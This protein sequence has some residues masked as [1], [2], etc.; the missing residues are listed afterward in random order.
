MPWV[1]GQSGN[2]GGRPPK[3]REQKEFERKMLELS[4]KAA[5]ILARKLDS[6]KFEEVRW[7]VETLLDRGFGKP[8]VSQDLDV[9]TNEQS[10]PTLADI[11]AQ[12]E[13]IKVLIPG[14]IA[15]VPND[16]AQAPGVDTGK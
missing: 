15:G 2:P 14:A 6:T 3:S 12:A 11:V 9:N 8:L 10:S 4:P 16:G 1:K 13:R 7:A 5:A